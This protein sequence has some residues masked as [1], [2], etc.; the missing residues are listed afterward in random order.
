MLPSSSKGRPQ[1]TF[2]ERWHLKKALHTTRFNLP[3][4]KINPSPGFQAAFFASAHPPWVGVGAARGQTLEGQ[5]SARGQGQGPGC[6][7]RPLGPAESHGAR[8][9][10]PRV[11]LFRPRSCTHG[12]H[13]GVWCLAHGSSVQGV[14]LCRPGRRWA[15]GSAPLPPAPAPLPHP[16]SL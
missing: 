14:L 8:T 12:I 7:C 10:R 1:W 9:N 13:E 3:Q 11:G 2:R 4:T 5:L 16:K 15:L 6:L